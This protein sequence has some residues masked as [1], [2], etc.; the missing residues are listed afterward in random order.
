[1]FV[2]TTAPS[3]AFLLPVKKYYTI[4]LDGRIMLYDNSCKSG[5][6]RNDYQDPEMN[7]NATYFLTMSQA[8]RHFAASRPHVIDAVAGFHNYMESS[9]DDVIKSCYGVSL[10]HECCDYDLLA[11]ARK[12]NRDAYKAMAAEMG[13]AVCA[14]DAIACKACQ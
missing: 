9:L 11:W 2:A 14:S 12:H 8:Q 6:Y 7:M 13:N 10:Y 3:G 5:Q 1:L 4:L